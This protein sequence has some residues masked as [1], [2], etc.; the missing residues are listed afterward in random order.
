MYISSLR[1][2]SSFFFFV[3]WFFVGLESF[4]NIKWDIGKDG[5]SR[6]STSL[7]EERDGASQ[8]LSMNPNCTKMSPSIGE[9]LERKAPMP[10]IID[11]ERK[12]RA[13]W[14]Q[15][16]TGIGVE[17]KDTDPQRNGAS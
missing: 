6:D 8:Y 9:D 5:E 1:T 10:H 3:L 12:R 13:K 14:Q 11:V 2:H 17:E 4:F 16:K 7:M 15:M